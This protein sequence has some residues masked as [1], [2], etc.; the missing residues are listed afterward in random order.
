MKS[1]VV[2][3]GVS[4]ILFF[5]MILVTL[6]LVRPAIRGF[7]QQLE[8]Y[9]T[10]FLAMVESKTG[11]V[12]SY[13]SLSPAILSVFRIKGIEVC[14]G[15]TKIPVLSIRKANL[16]YNLLRLLSGDI[17][18]AFSKLSISG[19][20]LEYD[21]MKS[22]RVVEK[23]MTLL[24]SSGENPLETSSTEKTAEDKAPASISL[25]FAIDIR[26]VNLHYRDNLMDVLVSF[27]DIAVSDT[28]SQGFL[29]AQGNGLSRVILQEAV[30]ASLPLELQK[31]VKDIS[32]IFSFEASIL[33]QL[34]G[35]TAGFTLASVSTTDFS[36]ARTSFFGEYNQGHVTVSTMQGNIPLWLMAEMNLDASQLQVHAQM[37]EFDPFSLLRMRK[38]FPCWKR[39]VVPPFL[40]TTSSSWIPSLWPLIMRL[41]VGF[42]FQSN[43]CRWT[44]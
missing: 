36:L 8:A 37:D 29:S 20:T 17:Q 7:S 40:E 10:E 11:L 4:S 9:R 30:L 39:F 24:S 15:E 2:K 5:S 1:K 19:I 33:P 12:V 32:I 28:A 23:L 31:S 41:L 21:A 26:D 16:S 44:C 38:K 22:S 18:G 27:N 13:D 42:S 34:D 6:A 14:D 3:I 25:P 35:S 43:C